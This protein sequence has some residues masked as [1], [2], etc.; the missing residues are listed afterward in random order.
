MPVFA[1]QTRYNVSTATTDLIWKREK[2]KKKQNDKTDL[3]K[4][5]T[6]ENHWYRGYSQYTKQVSIVT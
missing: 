3:Y 6:H 1:Q 2:E 5:D 4:N